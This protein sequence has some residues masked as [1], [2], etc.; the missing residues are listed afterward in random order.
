MGY[1][2]IVGVSIP[3]HFF[4]L[5]NIAMKKL[6]IGLLIAAAG[7][8]IFFLPR[9]KNKSM[10]AN[11]FQQEQIIGKWKLDSLLFATV[12][13]DSFM[14]GTMGMVDSNLRKY[15]YEFTRDG[16]IAFSLGDSLIKDSSGYEWYEEDKL[17]WKENPA[18]SSGGIFKVSQLTNDSLAL[19]S[20]NSSVLLFT[21]VK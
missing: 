16:S 9:E 13:N 11:N 4:H 6:F 8:A 15:H 3:E 1:F 7:A 2:L 5:K 19:Q 14:P 12:S 20:K 17:V 18:D 10:T 21:K